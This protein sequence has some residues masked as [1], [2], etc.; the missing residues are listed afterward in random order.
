MVPSWREVVDADDVDIACVGLP[1]HEHRAAVEALAADIKRFVERPA[2]TMRV[3]PAPDAPPGA[4][5]GE[6]P[7]DWLAPAPWK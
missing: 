3:M 2:E 6:S 5:I 1:N 7:Q 4:P